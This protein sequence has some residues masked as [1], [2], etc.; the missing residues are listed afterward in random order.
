MHDWRGLSFAFVHLIIPMYDLT[1]TKNTPWYWSRNITPDNKCHIGEVDN[2]VAMFMSYP[3]RS[4]LGCWK[5]NK[6]VL[7]KRLNKKVEFEIVC[8]AVCGDDGDSLFEVGLFSQRQDSTSKSSMSES[9]RRWSKRAW[10]MIGELEAW[11]EARQKQVYSVW[12]SFG[13]R[14]PTYIP[15]YPPTL[16][17]PIEVGLVSRGQEYG[18]GGCQAEMEGV[19]YVCKWVSTTQN[20]E[21]V[22]RLWHAKAVDLS[23]GTRLRLPPSPSTAIHCG[24][25]GEKAASFQFGVRSDRDTAQ[26]IISSSH[27]EWV[28]WSRVSSKSAAAGSIRTHARHLLMPHS[29]NLLKKKLNIFRT[30]KFLPLESRRNRRGTRCHSHPSQ[31]VQGKC[32]F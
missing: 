11:E 3:Y 31:S 18:G 4:P 28:D 10:K 5:L 7:E 26:V 30:S 13:P 12:A 9:V 16:Y 6:S 24:V 1:M 19:T 8:F 20:D 25:K 27:R 21:K 17:I 22:L 2:K 14:V 32:N 15:T 23:R 29:R